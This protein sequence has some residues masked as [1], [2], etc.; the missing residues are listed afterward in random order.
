[1]PRIAAR[2]LVALSVAAI[3]TWVVIAAARVGYPYALEWQEGGLLSHVLRARAGRSLYAEPDVAFTAFPY[4]PV[5]VYLV[6]LVGE[7]LLALRLV[8]IAATLV[9]LGLL[10]Q[11]GRR[12]SGQW[13][14][15]L[16]A[17][18]VFAATYR[19]SGSWFDVGRVDLCALAF[20]LGSLHLARFGETGRSIAIAG[21]LAALAILTKQTMALVAL[22]AI[23]PLWR[24]NR[25]LALGFGASSVLLTGLGLGLLHLTSGGWSTWY[26]F[27][28]LRGHPWVEPMKFWVRDLP[29]L[30]PAVVLIVWG[31]YPLIPAACLVGAAWLGRAHQGGAENTLLPMA[32]LAAL[33]VGEAL[34]KLKHPAVLGLAALQILVLVRDPREV[35]PTQADRDAGAA[36]VAELRAVEGPVFAPH[37]V[38]LALAAGKPACVHAQAVVD[39]LSSRGNGDKAARFVE[40]LEDALSRRTFGAALLADPWD[41]LLGLVRGYPFLRDLLPG[42]DA[43]LLRPRTGHPHRPRW[44]RTPRQP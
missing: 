24:R 3:L 36:I 33:G 13:L 1:M 10:V 26:L 41:D 8:S 30:T 27:D 20:A 25:D 39:L 5:Y 38:E 22:P 4:P 37:Q 19:W 43:E 12:A 17:A 31:R 21:A 28:L 15:G 44:L 11:H 7:S 23:V 42:A 29:W 40:K 18:G 34:G 16:A 2:L 9:V 32:L 35:L 14:P 6:A